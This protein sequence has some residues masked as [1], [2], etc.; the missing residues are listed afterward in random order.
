MIAQIFVADPIPGA[1]QL[2]ESGFKPTAMQN[3][4]IPSRDM[5]TMVATVNGGVAYRNQMIPMFAEE[6]RNSTH[7]GDIYEIFLRTHY[8]FQTRHLNQ[9]PLFCS[10]LTQML[11]LRNIFKSTSAL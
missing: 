10:T 5:I 11:S 8:R 1:S 9:I 7:H 6:L 4:A 2:H 3:F